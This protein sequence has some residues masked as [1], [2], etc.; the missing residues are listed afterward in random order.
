MFQMWMPSNPVPTGSPM[1]VAFAF[2]P[3]EFDESHVRTRMLPC[4]TT[5]PWPDV[6]RHASVL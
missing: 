3:V 1:H 2:A 5:S 6:W 4:T